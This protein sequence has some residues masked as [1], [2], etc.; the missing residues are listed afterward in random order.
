MPG[1]WLLLAGPG[2]RRVYQKTRHITTGAKCLRV[3]R[4]KERGWVQARR[5]Y[6][7]TKG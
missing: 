6:T 7:M 1:Y 3:W 5:R 2:I 4:R